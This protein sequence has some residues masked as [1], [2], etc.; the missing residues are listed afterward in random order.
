MTTIAIISTATITFAIGFF[1]GLYMSAK[2][3]R[4]GRVDNVKV[5]K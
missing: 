3:I 4:E 2:V 1:F 5:V